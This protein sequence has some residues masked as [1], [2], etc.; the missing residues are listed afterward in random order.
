M[1]TNYLISMSNNEKYDYYNSIIELDEPKENIISIKLYN[2]NGKYPIS[3]VRKYKFQSLK[4]IEINSNVTTIF[5][6]L[7]T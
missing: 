2:L 1:A 5:E 6:S 7:M 3:V 4:N